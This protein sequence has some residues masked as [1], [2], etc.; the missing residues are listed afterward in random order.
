MHIYNPSA[1][2]PGFLDPKRNGCVIVSGTDIIV[3][4]KY[5]TLVPKP[6]ARFSYQHR[7]DQNYSALPVGVDIDGNNLYSGKIMHYLVRLGHV[8][9]QMETLIHEQYS[10]GNVTYT[11]SFD[12]L[13]LKEN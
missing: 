3:E 12:V 5:Q 4:K 7:F 13:S 1:I 9:Y 10:G 6:S 8:D 2:I 11:N